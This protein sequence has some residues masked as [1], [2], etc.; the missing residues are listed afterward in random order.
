MASITPF[1]AVRPAKDKSHLVPS[2]SNISYTKKDLNEKL[3]GNPF[4]FLHILHPDFHLPDKS[5]PG[6]LLRMQ[7]IKEKYNY[8]IQKEILLRDTTPSL[9]VYNQQKNGISH[10]G[11]IACT[12]V[13][14]YLSK[15]I[16]KHED[17]LEQREMKLKEYLSNVSLHA[18]PV[19]LFYEQNTEI[20]ELIEQTTQA[21]PEYDFTTTDWIRH[22]LWIVSKEEEIQKF[23]AAFKQ[24][25]TLFIADGHHRLAA[26]TLY[27]KE[28]RDL[29]PNYTGLEPFNYFLSILFSEEQL[30][31]Y[32]YNRMV[33]L[34]DFFSVA[35]LL[36]K[37][38]QYFT[39]TKIE[40]GFMPE[41]HTLA[42]LFIHNRW[43]KLEIKPEFLSNFKKHEI[44]ST[45]IID[46]YLFTP[47]LGITDLRNDKR[48]QF[49]SGNEG[50]ENLIKKMKRTESQMAFTFC[51]VEI[52]KIKTYA[53]QN[54]VMPPKSTWIEPKLRSGFT[55]YEL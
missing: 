47:I 32:R 17:T 1:K 53:L 15:Q 19:C 13:D 12:S 45:N 31:I 36:E 16:K 44:I 3:S 55:I 30:R 48:V 54:E 51:R 35:E 43:Y 52:E 46:K 39:I 2:R 26:S 21:H 49:I 33:K 29:N 41:Q 7:R 5:K 6:S 42:G 18:E 14:E 20:Q 38:K 37:I 24:V 22:T 4:T 25:E 50:I 40:E 11:I 27:C 34:D 28:Q 8:F 23:Q 9:Y 10:I